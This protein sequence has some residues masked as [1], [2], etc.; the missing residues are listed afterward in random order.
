MGLILAAKK[1]WQ[2][3]GFPTRSNTNWVVQT[4]KLE[5]LDLGTRG[6]ILSTVYSE[7][8]GADKLRDTKLIMI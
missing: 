8:K 1:N 6:I 4:L 5:H 2:S 3:S 7:I